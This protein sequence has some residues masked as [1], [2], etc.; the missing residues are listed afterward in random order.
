MSDSG[1]GNG[2]IHGLSSPCDSRC[3]VRP[4]YSEVPRA[5]IRVDGFT[6]G[7]LASCLCAAMR[8]LS[9]HERVG[10]LASSKSARA[11]GPSYGC[12]M[13]RIIENEGMEWCAPLQK[14]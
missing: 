11:C 12:K 2:L 4:P 9:L 10:R 1:P 7:N 8:G 6:E 3:N 13:L 14:V 5:N